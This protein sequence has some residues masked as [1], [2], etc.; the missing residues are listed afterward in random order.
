MFHA[1]ISESNSGQ[2]ADEVRKITYHAQ[3]LHFSEI[4]TPPSK[5]GEKIKNLHGFQKFLS[6]T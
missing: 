3:T 4:L 1:E 2:F 6:S 5:R